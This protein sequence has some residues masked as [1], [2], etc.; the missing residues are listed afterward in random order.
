MTQKARGNIYR[1]KLRTADEA[2]RMIRSG[3]RVFIGSSCGEP[4]H[5][6]DA[7]MDNAGYF[8]DVEIVR[9]L[10]LE[11]SLLALMAD[12]YRGHNFHVRSIYQGS[13]QTKSL[14]ANRR[15]ITPMNLC[16]VPDVFKKRLLP[17]HVALIQVSPPDNYGWMSLGISVDVTLAAAQTADVVVAQ[18]NPRMPRVPGH[19]FIHVK[20]VDVIVEKEEELL[21]AYDLPVYESAMEIAGITANLIADGATVQLGLAELSGAI[22]NALAGKNDLGVH[23]EILSDDLMQLVSKGV[24]TNRYKQINEGKLIASGAIGS[25]KLYQKLHNNVS[26]EFRPSDY[27]N[28][29]AVIAQNN[30]MVAIN[31]ARTM[32]LSGQVYADALPQNHFSGVTGMLDFV[33]GASMSAGGKSIIV[34]SAR[35][36]DGKASRIICKADV[37]SIVIPKG[38][39][40]YVV[41]EFGVVNL[42]GKNIQERAMA[43]ISLAHPD[44]RDELFHEA[45]QAGFIDRNR[46]LNESLFGVYPARIEETR[47]YDGQLVTFRPAKPVDERLIQEHFYSMDDEDVKSRFFGIRRSFYREDMQDMAQVDYIKNLSIVAVTGELGFEKL[48]GLGMYALEQGTVAEVGFSVSKE[49]QGKGIASVLLEKLTEAARENGITSLVA[50]THASNEGMIKLFNKLPYNVETTLKDGALVLSCNF[51]IK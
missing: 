44:F 31:F 8:S 12:E 25:K 9:L 5:L 21:T 22:A 15:F 36:I 39:V 29:P 38:Y 32:D 18:V 47:K 3:Q 48:I 19:S 17:L 4:Q 24:V 16:A 2:V 28:H 1:S 27:V 50:Y 33:M 45:Q 46:T 11:G 10:S 37:G 43:M 14:R 34:I 20:D 51:E 41:S 26:I 7:L 30:N 6:V 13:D 42:F 35:S 40:S 23:T 49:W